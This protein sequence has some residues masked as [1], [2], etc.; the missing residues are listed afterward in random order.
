MCTNRIFVYFWRIV[1]LFNGIIYTSYFNIL[2]LYFSRYCLK[3]YEIAPPIA[4]PCTC[5]CN[6]SVTGKGASTARKIFRNF[7]HV[8]RKDPLP[9]SHN[10]EMS[11]K[12][13]V[14]LFQLIINKRYSLHTSN[15]LVYS[16]YRYILIAVP[17]NFGSTVWCEHLFPGWRNICV[18][19]YTYFILCYIPCLS[20]DIECIA[21]V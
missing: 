11:Y 14:R 8:L 18:S 7:L 10:S 16:F 20:L 19:Y 15:I 3:Y 13:F 21:R 12:L 2:K 1:K 6:S 17:F 4:E 9:S 5:Q